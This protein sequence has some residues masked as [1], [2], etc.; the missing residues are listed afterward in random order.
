[1]ASVKRRPVT[2]PNSFIF[3]VFGD[4]V[5]AYGD[6]IWVGSL[7]RLMAEFGLSEQA[8]RA[9]VSRMSRQ[10]WLESTRRGG[11]SYYSVTALG[12]RRVD[13]VSKRIYVAPQTDWDGRWRMLSYTVPEAKRELRD[14]LRKDLTVLGLGPLSASLWISPRDVLDAVRDAIRDGELADRVDFFVA[15]Y[16]GPHTSEELVRKCWNLDAIGHAYEEFI[17]R[18]ATSQRSL[19]DVDAFVTRIWLVHDFRK[20]VY[21]DPGLPAALLPND[22]PGTRAG[23]LFRDYYAALRPRAVRFFESV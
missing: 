12:K 9:A 11:R 1:M 18:Y 21:L 5:H 10:G 16:E 8:V 4:F 20:F 23:V 15:E 14:R 17:A 2:R 3:T 7:V 19:S 6:A 13:E 22:W